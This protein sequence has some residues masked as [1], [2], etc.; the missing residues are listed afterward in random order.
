MTTLPFAFA[1]IDDR[2]RSWD[3]H[4][5]V[6]TARRV[7]LVGAIVLLGI[8][9]LFQGRGPAATDA[10][11]SSSMSPDALRHDAEAIASSGSPAVAGLAA[12]VA[13]AQ[14]ARDALQRKLEALK[15]YT[16]GQVTPILPADTADD[17]EQRRGRQYADVAAGSFTAR[18]ASAQRAVDDAERAEHDA[19]AKYYAALAAAAQAESARQ[20]SARSAAGQ[21]TE[22][23][24]VSSGTC[25]G[26][27]ACFLSCTRA[28]ESDTAGGYRAVSPDGVYHGAYQFD[29][30]TWDSTAQAVGRPDL[31]GVDPATA[32]PADQDTLATALYKMRGN[33][34]WG[35]RC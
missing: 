22:I 18:L 4:R 5:V 30:T 12:R 25:S 13:E 28:H 33:E 14:S 10:H 8:S 19:V 11:G 34:P 32:S 3:P 23:A 27:V 31:V 2:V 29:Q 26:A 1:P 20:E 16:Y 17:L 24:P 35:G 15:V 7:A 6:V 21:G 9:L